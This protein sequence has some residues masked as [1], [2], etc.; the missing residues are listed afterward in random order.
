MRI[1]LVQHRAGTDHRANV[2]RGL[3]AVAQAAASGARLVAFPELAFTPFFPCCRAS[4]ATPVVRGEPVPGPTTDLFASLAAKL[5]VVIV[6]NLYERDGD[7]AYDSSPV[8]DA[9]GRLLGTTRMLHIAQIGVPD[10][11]HSIR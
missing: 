6:L 3:E 5:G 11:F 4:G 9:D 2:S 8:I 1:A 10:R 7:G